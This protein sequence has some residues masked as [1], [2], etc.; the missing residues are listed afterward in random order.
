MKGG[1]T[2]GI[3]FP[4]ALVELSRS[5]QFKNI[6]GTSAGAIAAA[7]AAA[8][9]LGRQTRGTSFE[10]L[11]RLAPDLGQIDPRTG[12]SRLFGLFQ[13]QHRT[14]ALF[15][16]TTAALGGGWSAVPRVILTA[17]RHAWLAAIIGALPG[18]WLLWAFWSGETGNT[19]IVGFAISLSVLL[20]GAALATIGY[21]IRILSRRLP[22]NQFGLCT[23]MPGATPATFPPLTV[24]LADYLDRTARRPVDGPPLTFGDLWQ[25]RDPEGERLVNL[26]MMTTCLTHGRPYR[27]PLRDD[28]EV[29]ENS[30]FFFHESEFRALFPARVVQWMLDHPPSYNESESSE[31]NRE[32]Q[33]LAAKNFHPIPAPADLPVIVATR[34]SLSFPL[35][36]S[37]VPLH[38]ID[39][40]RREPDRQ[41]PSRCWFSDGGICSNFPIH[42][43]DSVLPR[44]PTFAINLAEKHPD[45]PAGV[46]LP[47]KNNSGLAERWNH[48]AASGGLGAVFGFLAA[49]VNTAKDWPD[50]LQ[51]RLPGYRDR[52]A[53]ISLEAAD[54]GLNLD[55]PAER[56]DR[57]AGYGA[58]AGGEF[59]RRFGPEPRPADVDLTW[60]NHRRIRLRATLAGLEELVTR[61]DQSCA[62]P[63]AGDASYEAI[64]EL[65]RPYPWRAAQR[66]AAAQL[67]AQVRALAQSAAASNVS[68]TEGAPRP[69]AELRVHPRT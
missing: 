46:Y 51:S 26:E 17:L 61:L 49:I 6:G 63:G 42:F 5:F 8:A 7:V 47:K 36:L 56:I 30:P 4:R 68:V 58:I 65:D 10:A 2:S 16:V 37:A 21:Y 69:R 15:A 24:W 59:A 28:T 44:W 38:A 67:L 54:G 12:R 27:L 22:E 23:G 20:A 41:Q 18:I 1:I 43:F 39:F 3:V 66:I 31:S 55:M 57:L 50:T 9:E 14:V 64:L 13:P 11:D 33:A 35:L 53:T 19:P 34:M 29:R 32:R 40:S 62:S 60:E 52:I 45:Y 48:F 25:T